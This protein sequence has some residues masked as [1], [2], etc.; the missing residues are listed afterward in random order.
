M[1][2]QTVVVQEAAGRVLCCTIFRPGGKKL[3]SKGHIISEEDIRLMQTEGMDQVWVTEL[4]DPGSVLGRVAPCRY[5]RRVSSRPWRR[6]RRR[7]TGP[8][9]ETCG[10]PTNPA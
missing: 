4:E 3:L 1:K 6:E 7:H 8:A 9:A 10:R 2:A 5:R